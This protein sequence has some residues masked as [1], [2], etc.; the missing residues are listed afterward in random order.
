M[1]KIKKIINIFYDDE[2][3]SIKKM[4]IKEKEYEK[5]KLLLHD[6]IMYEQEYIKEFTVKSQKGITIQIINN[7]NNFMQKL[8]ET[9]DKQN[10]IVSDVEDKYHKSQLVWNKKRT[11]RL[12]LD[13]L[14]NR[15][16]AKVFK[17][18]MRLE[19]K[20]QDDMTSIRFRGSNNQ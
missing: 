12:S 9:I 14:N 4:N 5:Q 6:L 13:K 11:K 7:F 2:I 15:I 20:E 8:K 16:D 18:L 10:I 17:R 3:Q 19:Q 1:R